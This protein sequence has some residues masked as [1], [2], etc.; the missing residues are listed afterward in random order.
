M[1]YIAYA[2]LLVALTGC[3]P[4]MN[5]RPV[6]DGSTTVP[7]RT[8]E[9]TKPDNTAVNER[10]RDGNTKTPVVGQD[11][12]SEDVKITADI[13]KLIL[14]TDGMSINAQNSKIMTSKGHVTLRGPVASDD[15][16]AKVERLA[17]DVAGERM[18]TNELEVAEE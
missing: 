17:K 9:P 11:E 6:P 2:V 10:D 3:D 18:V 5:D 16:K 15:E 12:N 4:A 13:R 1:R 7:D 8:V 14:A